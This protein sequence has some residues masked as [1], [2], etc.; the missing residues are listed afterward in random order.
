[1]DPKAYQRSLDYLYGLERFGMIFDLTQVEKILK[2]IDEPHREVQAIHIGGTNGKGSTAAMIASILQKEGYRVGLYTSPHLLRFTERIKVDGKEIERDEVVELAEWMREKIEAAGITLPF[3]FFDFTTSMAFLYFKQKMVDLAILE[4]GLGGRLDSTN[5]VDPLLSIITN[6]DKDHVEQLGRS[7]LK[8]A[9]EKAGIIKKGRPLITAATQ[10]RVLRLF[11]R[12]CKEKGAP[13][14][15]VGRD[16]RSEWTDDGNFNYE[17]LHRKL[18][19]VHLNLLGFHQITNG[20]TALGAM[21]VLEEL[22]YT[23]STDAMMEGLREVNW[24]GRLEMV[25]SS[26]RVV[27]DGAHNPAGALVLRAALEKEFQYD[28]LILLVGMM[29]DKDAK[30]FLETLAPLADHILLS[31]PHIDRAASPSV[32]LDVL[33]RKGKKAEV[34]EEMKEAI[35]KSLSLTREEDLLCITGSLYTIGEAK[36]HFGP[37]RG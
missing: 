13:Y 10:P 17:G 23:V 12:T 33:G 27:L 14:F 26:P 24:P 11:S 19:N 7:L 28:R 32:L 34:I 8:I 35:E 30:T 36:S 37:T 6:I 21:E 5:V 20:T 18:W 25:S 22:G 4:V 15:R 9:G 1:M 29:K 16:F 2:A 31:K 3:T